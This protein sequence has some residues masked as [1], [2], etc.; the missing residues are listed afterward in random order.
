MLKRIFIITGIL[1]VAIASLSLLNKHSDVDT[2]IANKVEPEALSTKEQEL[3][4]SI[5]NSVTEKIHEK[6]G[7]LEFAVS[8]NSEIELKVKIKENEEY[9]NSVKKD[10]ESIATNVI[11]SST[12]KD[13]TVVIERMD[14]SLTSEETEK[15]NKELSH[16]ALSLMEGLKHNDVF[17]NINTEYQNENQKSITIQTSLK[18]SDKDAHKLVLEIEK[19]VNEILHSKELNSLSNI[20][21]YEIKILNAKGEVVN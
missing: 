7:D 17:G 15:I 11:K 13:Y 3:H 2:P 18:G 21:S 4:F 1:I 19:T 20:D 14:L 5:L 10:I 9:F 8:S 16:I 12:L 6:Y